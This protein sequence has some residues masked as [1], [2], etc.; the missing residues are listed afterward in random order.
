MESRRSQPPECCPARPQG[1]GGGGERFF[2]FVCLWEWGIGFFG[3]V[4]FSPE[5]AGFTQKTAIEE[6]GVAL[7]L[8][9]P[10]L[11]PAAGAPQV[12]QFLPKDRCASC[13]TEDGTPVRLANDVLPK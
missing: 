2:F 13:P 8:C 3:F 12:S 11:L 6:R 5:S 1:S 10:C 4:L 7:T 9:L